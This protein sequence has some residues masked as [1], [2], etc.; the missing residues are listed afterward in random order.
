MSATNA[1]NVE[2]PISSGEEDNV[3]GPNGHDDE[4]IEEVIDD[5]PEKDQDKEDGE[6]DDDDGADEEIYD[7]EELV[8][9]K[10]VKGKLMFFIK[11]KGYP[12]SDNTWEPAENIESKELIDEYWKNNPSTPAS[13]GA[14]RKRTALGARN[15]QS[16]G[17]GVDP[18]FDV[19]DEDEA[20]LS[21]S[22]KFV[23]KARRPERAVSPRRL[24]KSDAAVN[25]SDVVTL[26]DADDGDGEEPDGQLYIGDSISPHIAALSSWEDHVEQIDTVEE[27]VEGQLM[28]FIKW[29]NGIRSA[30]PSPIAN[31]KC[32]QAMIRFYESHIKFR[33]TGEEEEADVNEAEA[34][35]SAVKETGLDDIGGQGKSTGDARFEEITNTVVS[36][37]ATPDTLNVTTTESV[38]KSIWTTKTL[39]PSPTIPQITTDITPLRNEED[40]GSHD[41]VDEQPNTIPMLS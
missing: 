19:G 7:V 34:T 27:Y 35:E 5:Q 2:D 22:R 17:G 38:A 37:E 21:L 41:N 9:H 6:G 13:S 36:I 14:K 3:A 11:W 1:R 23:K 8:A 4:G 26:D 33:R 32:P 39:A 29:K 31:K 10:K 28:V 16:N 18:V 30:H 15:R 24:R 40:T 20:E 25:Y 12:S